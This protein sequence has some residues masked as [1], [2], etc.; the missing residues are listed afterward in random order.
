MNQGSFQIWGVEGRGATPAWSLGAT[1]V[2]EETIHDA[3]EPHAERLATIV[4]LQARQAVEP[5][6]DGGQPSAHRSKTFR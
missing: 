6:L 4:L 1:I 5:K 3:R 2:L